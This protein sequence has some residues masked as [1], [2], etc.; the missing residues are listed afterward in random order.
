MRAWV[1]DNPGPI[2]SAPM[3]MVEL[4]DPE[5]GPGELRI[6]VNVCGICHTDLHEAEGELEPHKLP[7]VPGHQVVG[8]VDKIGA[9]VKGF[10][11]GERV[12]VC[13]L[14]SACGEC[15]FCKNNLENL[16][17]DAKFTGW[18]YDGGYAE[19]MISRAEYTFKLPQGYDDLKVAPLLCA[20]VIGW[21]S[22][23]LSE[24]KK[25]EIL[26]LFGFGAS[27]HI[28]CQIARYLGI[29]VYAFSR[30]EH[31]RQLALKLGA[32]WAGSAKDNPPKK[33]DR[34]I[35]FAPAGQVLLDALR[36][37]RP[38]GTIAINAVYMSPI[39]EMDYN[40]LLYG[41]KTIRSVS[42]LTKE[43]AKELLEIAPKVP[44]QSEI[45][46]FEFEDALRAL[47]LVKQAKIQG[48][49]VLKIKR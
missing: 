19:Y 12:G 28:V 46:V 29:E 6:R 48:A 30:S 5:P 43:D 35:I 40:Q 21:R 11:L 4:A 2:E 20:G 42:N 7:V 38:A 10:S 14:Y 23:K 15:F 17:P 32:S 3:R 25:G 34:A 33:I 47:N 24:A 1:I 16:C 13:W 37:L 9:G 49:G 18:D 27:A 41:E 31:H 26:G 45:E 44:I 36:H 39:P 22:L 8:V